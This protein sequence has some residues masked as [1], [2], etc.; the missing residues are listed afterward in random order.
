MHRTVSTWEGFRELWAGPL[1][2]RMEGECRLPDY[3]LP[4]LDDVIDQL[5]RDPDTRIWRGSPG[6]SLDKTDISDQFRRLPHDEAMRSGF[7]ISHFKLTKFY[8]PGKMLCG[9]EDQCLLPWL[10]WLEEV[11]F[12]YERYY[13]IIFVS[14]CRCCT[15]FHVD[16]TNV[17]AWQIYGNKTWHGAKDPERWAPHETR[18][19]WRNT[20]R[21]P[22]M[23]PEHLL[24]H[25]MG[26]GDML[27]NAMLT[28]HWVD[29]GIGEPGMSINIA[30]DGLR[31]SGQLCSHEQ[32][33][34]DH[35]KAQ[36][37][38]V[39]LAGKAPGEY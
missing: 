15:N 30:I 12:T 34:R 9:F 10:C 23:K 37:E 16:P 1:N 14:G 20:S 26:P 8:E 39:N 33:L 18:M 2:L 31:L 5:R 24:A 17:L 32:E 29:G 7:Q 35:L 36:G 11:G 6:N 22:G 4:P 25:E 38:E 21:P 3:A 28:P 13:P 27:W 19:N